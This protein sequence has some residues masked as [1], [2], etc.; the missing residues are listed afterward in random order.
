[1]VSIKAALLLAIATAVYASPLSSD[2]PDVGFHTSFNATLAARYLD[3]DTETAGPCKQGKCP[4]Y[5]QTFDLMNTYESGQ[6]YEIRVKDCGKCYKKRVGRNGSGCYDYTACKIKKT[7]CVDPV[8]NRAH[9]VQKDNNE[10][11]CYRMKPVGLGGCDMYIKQ[12][13]LWTPES[14]VPCDW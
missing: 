7:I 9:R 8:K 1:M 12:V 3:R 2:T 5:N 13:N 14:E 6:R 11:T 4:D 10:K